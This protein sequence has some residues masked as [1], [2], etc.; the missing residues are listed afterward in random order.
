[1][2]S[3]P[4]LGKGEEPY[5]LFHA[6]YFGDL[7]LVKRLLNLLDAKDGL[8]EAIASIKDDD[9]ATLLH[10]AAAGGQTKVCKYL[11]EEVKVDVDLREELDQKSFGSLGESP[12][13]YASKCGHYRTAVYLLKKGANP[14]AAHAVIGLTPLHCAVSGGSKKLLKL[15]ISKGANLNAVADCGTPLHL[16]AGCGN[17]DCVEVLLDN[18]ADPNMIVHD[19]HSPLMT[20]IGAKSIECMKLLLKA[21]AD[22]NLSGPI[23]MSPLSLAASGGSTEIIQCLLSAGADPNVIDNLTGV[24]PVEEAALHHNHEAVRILLPVTSPIPIISDWSYAGIMRHVHS[25]EGEEG[26]ERHLK[27]DTLFSKSKGE[28]LINKKDYM[29]AIYWYTKVIRASPTDADALSNRSL[30]WAQLE[31]GEEALKDAHC[32]ILLRPGWAKAYYRAGVAWM[33]LKEFEKAAD[34]FYDGWKLDLEDEELEHAFW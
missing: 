31:M 3:V 30:C 24:K 34:A 16:A 10:V 15:L 13:H 18:H 28:E 19:I 6:A 26:R 23:G 22:P 7:P 14:N 20:S 29:G 12:L 33:L 9:G 27:E 8:P 2:A 11:V 4:P 17:E 25:K 21:G 5:R 1:M 32:C